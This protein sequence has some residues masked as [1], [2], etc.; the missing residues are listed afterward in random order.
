MNW[1][2]VYG[3]SGLYQRSKGQRGQVT[4]TTQELGQRGQVTTTTQEL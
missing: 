4:T 3:H 1:S 2:I